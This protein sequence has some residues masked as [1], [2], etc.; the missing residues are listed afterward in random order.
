MKKHL[1]LAMTAVLGAGA[2][3]SAKTLVTNESLESD[4]VDGAVIVLQ[5]KDTNGGYDTYLDGA[6]PKSATINV[7]SLHRVVGVDGGFLLQNLDD[8]TYMYYTGNGNPIEYTEEESE[9]AVFTASIAEPTGWTTKPDDVIAGVNTVRFTTEGNEFLN[10]SEKANVPKFFTGTGGFSAWYVYVMS[11]E[12]V[13][14]MTTVPPTTVTLNLPDCFG[15]P[16]SVQIENVAAGTDVTSLATTSLDFFTPA[17]IQEEDHAVTPDNNTFTV[18]GDWS[19]PFELNQVYRMDMRKAM[20]NNCTN[21]YYDSTTH[22]IKTRNVTEAEAFVPA[23]LFYLAG[24]G[25]EDG[26]LQVTL[27]AIAANSKHGFEVT[28]DNN[29]IGAVTE[30][31]TTFAVV[32]NSNGSEGVSL[33]HP[34]NSNCH[35]NDINGTLG[36][37]A[38]AAS[39]NDGGSFIRFLELSEEDFDGIAEGVTINGYEVTPDAGR[40]AAAAESRSA[41]DIA[42]LFAALNAEATGMWAREIA[43]QWLGEGLGKYHGLTSEELEAAIAAVDYTASADDIIDAT[44]AIVATLDKLEINQPEAGRFYRLSNEDGF[45]LSSLVSTEGRIDMLDDPNQNMPETIVYLDETNRLV[46]WASGLV[47]GNFATQEDRHFV[48]LSSDDASPETVFEGSHKMGLYYI[49]PCFDGE[50]TFY[51]YNANTVVDRGGFIEGQN[52]SLTSNKDGYCW[53]ISEVTELPILGS[54]ISHVGV[55]SPVALKLKEHT[56]IHNVTLDQGKA[57]TKTIEGDIPAMTPVLLEIGEQ[58][59]RSADND[60]IYLTIDYTAQTPETP[61][62]EEEGEATE[63]APRHFCGDIYASEPE[64]EKSYF[65]V[66]LPEGEEAVKFIAYEEEYVPGFTA[67]LAVPAEEAQESYAIESEPESSISEIAA[68]AEAQEKVYDLQGRRVSKTGRGLFITESGR[69]IIR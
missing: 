1:L 45:Y 51:I 21:F 42:A 50:K 15:Y 3:A 12:E 2:L 43:G 18:L 16:V 11:A 32:T 56:A 59:E 30:T 55:Y 39:K 13:E 25:F 4:I 20:T 49:S 34:D 69:K 47:L 62:A 10:T 65:T 9:A 26:H 58:A 68:P 22:Q 53:V 14:A 7:T 6:R 33:R 23:R 29:A 46:S 35:V 41:A 60:L 8:D 64:T 66:Q 5:C 52:P 57:L 27:H 37:W 36:I 24:E 63:E 67:M 17:G 19:F 54:E 28:T 40:L 44:D 31:P 38:H 61:A 48:L